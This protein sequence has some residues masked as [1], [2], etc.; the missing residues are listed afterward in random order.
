MIQDTSSQD[1]LVETKSSRKKWVGVSVIILIACVFGYLFLSSSTNAGLS[2][3]RDSLKFS[4][5]TKGNLIRDIVTTGRIIA[6]NA[7]QLYSPEQGYVLLKVKPGDSVENGDIVAI[8]DSP[9]LQNTMKQEQSALASLQSDLARQELDVRRQALLLNKQA[10]IANVE[11]VAAQREEKRAK[12]SIKDHLISQ[13]D[14]EEALDNLAK[15]E[16]TYKHAISEIE[17]ATDTLAFELKT[18]KEKVARQAL[19]VDD[20]T[21]QLAD[22]TIRASVSGV[23][24]NVL[25]QPNA[26]VAKNEPLMKLVDLTAYEAE[27]NVAESYANELG[28]GMSVELKVGVQKVIGKL[29]SISPE[30]VDRQVT[31]RVRFP[32]NS[33]QSIRQNQQVSAR[34]LLENKR[35]VLKVDR[36]SFL[37]A[38]GTTAYLVTGDLAERIDIQIGATSIREVEILSG[39]QEGDEIIVSNYE[40]FNQAATVLPR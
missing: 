31:A 2:S 13:I 3:S 27:L 26:L 11:L 25:I 24:G 35:D 39:L 16:V 20:L 22:L 15:A 37:Q 8:V 28:L 30:V 7:P 29:V 12:L 18:T 36:G 38:G 34:I 5:V 4:A 32:E 19:V 40:Q 33:V 1:T 21:R 23:V 9:E 17:L 14:L 6:S 10:D